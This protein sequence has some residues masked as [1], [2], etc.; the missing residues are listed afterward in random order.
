VNPRAGTVT[1][2]P[3]VTLDSGGLAKGLFADALAEMLADQPSFAIDCAGDLALGGRRAAPRALNV[4]SPFDGSTLHTFHMSRTAV[5]TSGIGRRS[6]L[7]RDGRPA[8]HLLDPSTGTP[9]FTGIVQAT[10]LAP[11][12]LMAEIYAKAALLSGPRAAEWW[13]AHGGVIVFDDGSHRVIEP[14]RNA[15]YRP[16]RQRRRVQSATSYALGARTPGARTSVRVRIGPHI[17][18]SSI[19]MHAAPRVGTTT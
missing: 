13:L 16:P 3:G 1:R 18:A 6:W 2:P 12:A 17:P 7:D 10:A 8:H 9:A 5:A 4:Q 15:V 14:P 11:S 19:P